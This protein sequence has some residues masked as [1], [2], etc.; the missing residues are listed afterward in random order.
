[1]DEHCGSG[2]QGPDPPLPVVEPYEPVPM[3]STKIVDPFKLAK[4]GPEEKKGG[5][6]FR[7]DLDRPKSHSSF[8][9]S[10]R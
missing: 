2:S 6:G 9:R 1:V 3:M 4:M 7:P 10:N 5:G 8:I